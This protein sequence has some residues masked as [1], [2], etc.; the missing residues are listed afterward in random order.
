MIKCNS[1]PTRLEQ[2]ISDLQSSVILS[3]VFWGYVHV[4][5]DTN[6]E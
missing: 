6:L 2:A 4:I 1:I 3:E 5:K